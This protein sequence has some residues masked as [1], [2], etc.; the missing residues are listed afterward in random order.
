MCPEMRTRQRAVAARSMSGLNGAPAAGVGLPVAL[1]VLLVLSLVGLAANQLRS[2]A[3]DNHATNVSSSRAYLASYSGVQLELVD[4]L[5]SSPCSC[6][7]ASRTLTFTTP[8]LAGCSAVLS[9]SSFV[10]A[11]ET[12]CDVSARSSCAGG[13]ASRVLEVRVK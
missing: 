6:T 11:G 9:C 13:V 4:V 12:Y 7:A 10:A 2:V 5:A 8:G 3:A 1:F